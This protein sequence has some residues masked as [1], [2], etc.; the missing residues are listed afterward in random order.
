MIHVGPE[1]NLIPATFNRLSDNIVQQTTGRG[2]GKLGMRA[3]SGMA[4]R[5]WLANIL[6]SRT[7][8][9]RAPAVKQII[10]EDW[11]LAAEVD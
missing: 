10:L 8:L 11:L 2:I 4:N 5:P 7:A 1:P 9:L 6:P 3:V